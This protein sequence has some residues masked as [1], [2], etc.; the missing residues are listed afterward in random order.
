MVVNVNL[1]AGDSSVLSFDCS[2][3]GYEEAI[4][5][6]AK[7]D[8]TNNTV[9]M[10]VNPTGNGELPTTSDYEG[11]PSWK[12]S[13]VY[14]MSRNS[15]HPIP[16]GKRVFILITSDKKATISVNAKIT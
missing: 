2:K 8:D 5:F 13:V 3:D 12:D 15:S 4:T 7:T 1:N 16:T 10:F 14:H 6:V 9:K 11:S